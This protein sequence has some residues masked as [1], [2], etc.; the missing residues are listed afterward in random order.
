VIAATGFR[1]ISGTWWDVS[2]CSTRR[3][4][5]V[6][7]GNEPSDAGPLLHWLFK[8]AARKPEST[9]HRRPPRRSKIT[10]GANAQVIDL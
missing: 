7:W 3:G 5:E 8:P 10:A 2:M 4:P 6:P 1:P 9:R